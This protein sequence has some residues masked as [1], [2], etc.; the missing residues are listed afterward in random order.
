MLA[1][2]EVAVRL[3][4]PQATMIPRSRFSAAYGLEFHPDRVI[5]NELAGQWRFEYT[6][7]SQ[8]HR[9]PV[10]PLSN[11]YGKPNVVVLGD[12][13]TFG[14]GVADGQEYPALLRQ[15]LAGSHG[16]VNLGTGGW[17]L[18]QELRRF[19]E[20][21]RQYEPRVV[22]LQFTGNDPS[23]NLLYPVTAVEGGRFAFHDRDE[24]QVISIVKRLL[25]DSIL[26]HSHLYALARA[27]LYYFMR[28]HEIAAT[29]VPAADSDTPVE[30]QVYLRLLDTFAGDLASRGVRLLII[31]VEDH[32]TAFPR[33]RAGMLSLQARGLARFIDLDE[34]FRTAPHERSPEGHWGPASHRSVADALAQE[35]ATPT[36]VASA[37]SAQ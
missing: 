30:E 22:V 10:L 6:A 12:S 28:G 8:G 9:G 33:I 18:T 4:D 5:V 19:Y 2:A 16:V 31:P 37:A 17:G 25:S 34:L 21:G 26:Q 1:V 3:I 29:A 32:L 14:Y 27:H 36:G 20:L 7:N 23:D 13:F 24:T 35:I 11:R 15:R